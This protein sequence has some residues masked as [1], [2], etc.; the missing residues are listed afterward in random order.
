MQKS[1]A[2]KPAPKSSPDRLTKVDR[3]IGVELTESQL[4]QATGGGKKV[5]IDF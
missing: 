2:A 4:G 1:K 3:K 5:K